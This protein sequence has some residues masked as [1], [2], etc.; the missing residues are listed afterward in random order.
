[1]SRITAI[2]VDPGSLSDS[3]SLRTNTPKHLAIMQKL[4]LQPLQPLL[5]FVDSTIKTSAQAAAGIVDL[6]V[7]Q[8]HPGERGFFDFTKKGESSP[9]SKDEHKQEALW[10][11]SA[12]WA[13][14][15]NDN[16]GLRDAV[17]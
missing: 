9:Q 7:G 10:I 14:I 2:A 15:T 6:A 5:R 3:R 1:L 4:V 12:Q 13:G 17:A 11:K 16:T 8:A